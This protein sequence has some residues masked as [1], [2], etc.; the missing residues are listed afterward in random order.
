[1][2]VIDWE[3]EKMLSWLGMWNSLW[4][5]PWDSLYW[6][7]AWGDLHWL[8][9]RGNLYWMGTWESE[10]GMWEKLWNL[11]QF[12][13]I[14]YQIQCDII[15][16]DNNYFFRPTCFFVSVAVFGGKFELQVSF[17]LFVMWLYGAFYLLLASFCKKTMNQELNNYDD[18]CF[19]N[20]RKGR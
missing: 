13:I 1:M 15:E 3:G 6:L 14:L 10:R 17:C 18:F 16:C 11:I 9:T 5:G 7:G 4:F 2:F 20:P 19:T 8:G 12:C